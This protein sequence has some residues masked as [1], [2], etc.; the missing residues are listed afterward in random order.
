MR[1]L[2]EHARG[3][4]PSAQALSPMAAFKAMFVDSASS[5]AG[6]P[7]SLMPK[8]RTLWYICCAV[9]FSLYAWPLLFHNGFSQMNSDEA[10][11]VW[12]ADHLSR[13]LGILFSEWAWR[14][15]PPLIPLIVGLLAR[16]MP[17]ELAVLIVT[18]ICAVLG[19][20][21]VYILGARLGG[22]LAGLIASV[23]L[24]TDPTYRALS[25]IL[26]LDIPLMILFVT[27]AWFSLLGGRKRIYAVAVGVVALFVKD[28]GILVLV[29]SLA[30]IAWD[31]LIG[32]GWRPA[33]V[34]GVVLAISAFAL[35]PI[36]YLQGHIPR[37]SWLAWFGW[38]GHEAQLKGWRILDNSL[39]WLVPDFPK[40]Y[41]ALIL[42][43]ASPLLF[44]MLS[45]F[46]L[47]TNLFLIAWIVAVL[48]P[49]LFSYT[50][51]ERV[52]LLFSPALYLLFALCL[53][54]AVELLKSPAVV[55][56]VLAVLL[57][58]SV[59]LLLMAQQ[60]PALAYYVKCRFQAH[61]PTGEWVRE[62]V[63][64]NGGVVFSRSP[65][66]LRYYSK[67]EFEKDGGVFYGRDE[68]TGIPWPVEKFEGVLHGIHEAAYLVVDFDEKDVPPWL[69][70]PSR[71]SAEAILALGFELVQ[72]IWVPV[73]PG[74]EFPANP[75][76]AQ[77]P[78]FLD[79]LGLS[80]YRNNGATKEKIGA[81]L[82][83]RNIRP[84]SVPH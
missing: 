32:R 41:M 4:S 82:F 51:D 31:Y 11:Y 69:A 58:S 61:R 56:G 50:S 55:S 44:K 26:L 9:L 40:R 48:G 45:H 19:L 71:E 57:A 67:S 25:N 49:F 79:H 53:S 21:M 14:R 13:D 39:G 75:F 63:L 43:G 74:C 42:L 12:K 5:D 8:S 59:F 72:V 60:S 54:R 35:L 24:A 83:R 65:H 22:P 6:I 68:W 81:A 7:V 62:H 15:H 76:Y 37:G 36:G 16:L 78:G 77:V 66:Q 73:A 80:S 47:R 1:S 34:L 17:I 27:S 23:L 46:A 30:C 52:I 10:N 20:V 84:L 33:A 70:P 64:P 38:L 29:Y 18:K 28:Y 2:F 3:D